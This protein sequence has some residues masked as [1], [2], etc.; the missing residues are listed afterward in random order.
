MKAIVV[1][2]TYNERENL[3]NFV[4]SVRAQPGNID[5]LVVDDNSPD[6]TGDLAEELAA[7]FPG[8]VSVLHRER[9]EGLGP[10]Y[11]A[12]FQHVLAHMDHD[13]IVQMDA[14]L[15]HDPGYLPAFL[16]AAQTYDLV[17]GSRYVKGISVVNW[18]FKR[19][20][21]SKTASQYVRIVT[22]LPFTD[23][24]GG[25][26]CWRRQTLEGIDL[27][28][29]S[30]RGYIFQTEMT[31][32]AHHMGFRV[33]E[34]PIIFYERNLGRSKI[35]GPIIVEALFRVGLLRFKRLD[36]SGT[37]RI[38]AS[39]TNPPMSPPCGL[40]ETVQGPVRATRFR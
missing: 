39:S 23:L 9:K 36:R 28:K 15:S 10:A 2:P 11:L 17:L 30:A 22:G 16:Q 31:Y 1:V 4:N 18:D 37:S 5:I 20:L 21:L 6:R 19:L 34:I 33:G 8:S 40:S 13:R 26:K 38:L 25:F 14:D 7:R 29:V 12:G 3:E 35:S 27:R 24:T 32:R